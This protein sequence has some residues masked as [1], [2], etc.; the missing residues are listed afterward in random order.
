MA[1]NNIKSAISQK[2]VQVKSLESVVT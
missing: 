2:I 1:Q